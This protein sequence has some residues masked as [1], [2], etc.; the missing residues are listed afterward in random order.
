MGLF[1]DEL[2]KYKLSVEARDG[3]SDEDGWNFFN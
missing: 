3:S 2:I 1:Y